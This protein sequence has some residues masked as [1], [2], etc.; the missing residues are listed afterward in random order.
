MKPV[1][2]SIHLEKFN[3]D[4]NTLH[5]KLCKDNDISLIDLRKYMLAALKSYIIINNYNIHTKFKLTYTDNIQELSSLFQVT[6]HFLDFFKQIATPLI[7]CSSEIHLPFLSISLDNSINILDRLNIDRE[8]V[9]IFQNACTHSNI[10]IFNIAAIT[11]KPVPYAVWA[12]DSHFVY[13]ENGISEFRKFSII[14]FSFHWVSSNSDECT[15][16]NKYVQSL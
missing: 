12:S 4:V 3:N 13:A 8:T 7:K 6:R 11:I 16:F 10:E 1:F 5:S 2:F 15:K 14:H 9:N